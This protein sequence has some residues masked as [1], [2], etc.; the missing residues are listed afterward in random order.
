MGDQKYLDE[1]ST[2]FD[3]VHVLEHPGG[4][5]APWNVTN[6]ELRGNRENVLVDSRPL[7]FFHYHSLRLYH[8]DL[9]ARVATA[10][11]YLR[12]GVPPVPLA[13]T[14]NYAAPETERRL[15]W[16]PYLRALG[17]ELE[18]LKRSGLAAFPGVQRVPLGEFGL[19][20]ARAVAR[21]S[22]ARGLALARRVDPSGWAALRFLTYRDS[23]KNKDVANQMI[24][25]TNH[26]LEHPELAPPYRSF[27]ELLNLLVD[28]PELPKPARFLDI[29]CGAGAYGE[30]IESWAPGR[31]DY[32]GADYSDE[33][34]EAARSR[35]PTRAFERRDLFEPDALQGFDVVFA[36]ALVDVLARYDDALDALFSAD[37]PWVVLHRQQIADR[38]HA[39]VAP[40]YRGQR[41]YRSYISREHLASVAARHGRR[42]AGTVMVDGQIQSFLLKR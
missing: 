28:E 21:R 41:T 16:N 15:V 22:K 11:G 19:R 32:L 26:Q 18:L 24:E 12:P 17:A 38:P 9:A 8:R 6:H 27:K 25:L 3:R 23:W 5:L 34:V 4:G 33:I 7:V 20:A 2:R 40:G 29:G 1:F 36:S 35:F 31:F 13:W 42:I 37:A 30:L 10:L 39:E 14:S